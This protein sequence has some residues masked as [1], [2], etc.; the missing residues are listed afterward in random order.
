[1]NQTIELIVRPN[2]STQIETKGFSGAACR[3]TSRFIELAI[4]HRQN[5]RL[6]G[7]FFQ[8]QTAVNTQQLRQG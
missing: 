3:D 7:E 4:G 6:T 8:T 1:M 5:E 2:G